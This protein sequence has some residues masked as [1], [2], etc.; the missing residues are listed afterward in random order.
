MLEVYDKC[1]KKNMRSTLKS[2]RTKET[3]IFRSAMEGRFPCQV[4][5][6]LLAFFILEQLVLF[7]FQLLAVD[8]NLN[9]CIC[10]FLFF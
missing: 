9:E 3:H 10:S 6:P 7:A 5:D 2:M 8:F 4:F 1:K